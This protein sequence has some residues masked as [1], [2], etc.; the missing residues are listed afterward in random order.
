[1]LIESTRIQ[2]RPIEMND[3]AAVFSYRSDKIANQYQSWIPEDLEDV[4]NFIKRNPA[5]FNLPETWFQ[6]VIINKETNQLIGDIGVHFFGNENAQVELG[7]TLNKLMQGK[8]YADESL[9][10]VIDYLF[11][12]LDKHRISASLDP[13]NRSSENMLKKLNFRKEAHFIKS[14]FH[15]NTWVDDVVYALLKED[16]IIS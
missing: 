9:R 13:Q 6:L 11:N 5:Q 14:Y 16:W 12:T 7:I 1:M 15:N 4:K 2:I 10:V 8:A 3:A